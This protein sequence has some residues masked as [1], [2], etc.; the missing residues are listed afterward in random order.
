MSGFE[1]TCA[2]DGREAYDRYCESGTGEFD[3][4]LMD[5][6]MPVMDGL[7]A[8]RRI[9]TSGR[10]DARTVAIIA[11]TA[12]AFDEDTKKSIASGMDGHLSKPIQ[13][14]QMLETLG[15]CIEKK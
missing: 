13:V 9:R 14:E 6:R 2:A 8:A 7:E 11:L 12:N 3:A 10:T 4:I 15:R 1:V 5:I